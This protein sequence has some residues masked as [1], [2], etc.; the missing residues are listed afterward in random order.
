MI[1]VTGDVHGDFARFRAARRKLRKGDTLIVCGDFGMLWDNG[2]AEQRRL[3]KLSKLPFTV[4]FLDGQHENYDLLAAYPTAEWNGGT[5]QQIAPNVVHL[6]RGEIYTVEGKRCFAFGGGESEPLELRRQS[7]TAWEE[8]IPDEAQ[9]RN[10]MEK[11]QQADF[12][13][14]YIFT[15]EPSGRV[16]TFFDR[17]EFSLNGIGAYLNWV[18]EKTSFAHWYFGCI[19]VDKRLSRKYTALFLNICR[20]EE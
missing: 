16:R 2:K 6:L 13:V 11:L 17:N 12:S 20:L 5:V 1:Y 4:A 3:K 10:G 8:C 7:N 18:E 14:D 15:H 9:M 19:H